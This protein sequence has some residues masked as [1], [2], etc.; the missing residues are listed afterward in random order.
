MKKVFLE[1]VSF[2]KKTI[3]ATIIVELFQVAVSLCATSV[4]G[5][6][7]EALFS[8]DTEYAVSN[9]GYILLCMGANILLVPA[10][11]YWGDFVCIKGS[12]RYGVHMFSHF[13]NMDYES[14]A[15]IPV[16]EVKERLES[17][18]IM[19]RN[20][21]ILVLARLIILPLGLTV[22]LV[23]MGKIS[24]IYML[25]AC[26]LALIALVT[27]VLTRNQTAIYEDEIRHYEADASTL[28]H[29]LFTLSP[30]A[31]IFHVWKK[32][33][34]DYDTLF[35]LHFRNTRSK[36]ITLG[37]IAQ[38]LI[39]LIGVFASCGILII[40]ALLKATN[41]ISAGSII[42]M[43]GY[44]AVLLSQMENIGYIF[45]MTKQ[46][47]NLGK[48]LEI[49]YS[50]KKQKLFEPTQNIF[51]IH[52]H[53]VSYYKD[54]TCILS[55]VNFD[56]NP[57]QKVALIGKNGAGKST[58][59]KILTG[60]YD[61]YDGEI[62]FGKTLQDNCSPESLALHYS[63]VSQNPFVYS[64]TVWENVRFGNFDVTDA[65]VENIMRELNLMHL[66]NY[67]IDEKGSN[68]SGG[69]LQRIS[70][71]RAVLKN[72]PLMIMDEPS[73]HLDYDCLTWINN[74]IKTSK[75]AILFVTHDMSMAEI[76]DSTIELKS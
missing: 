42:A 67:M 35:H 64:G 43:A 3:I 14:A 16:G 59:L 55:N 10:I 8:Q 21:V 7:S 9:L 33:I 24:I 58:L 45:T 39:A 72:R 11:S 74:Y 28:L 25:I 40:G 37:E 18:V 54:H 50:P 13:V 41:Q 4:A 6:F 61:S 19:F 2:S 36:A 32:L 26:L 56:I 38:N 69:E 66:R 1:C 48:R 68:L 70:L 20:A 23:Q 12:I 27:P 62:L 34:Y 31:K 53:N 22:L 47:K 63:Y 60:L 51:P 30:Y 29:E 75:Q 49:F 46:L 76:A 52:V 65:Q 15:S 5:S 71:A 17:D 44:Y 73:N 57:G